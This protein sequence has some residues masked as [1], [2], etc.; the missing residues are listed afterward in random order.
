MATIAGVHEM[1]RVSKCGHLWSE[2]TGSGP[3][4]GRG[5]GGG[6]NGKLC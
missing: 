1:M 4:G 2:L 6:G 3:G 5:S